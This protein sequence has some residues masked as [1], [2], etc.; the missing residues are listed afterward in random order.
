M[1]FVDEVS[2]TVSSGKGGPGK[3]SF[4]R[5]QM[6]VTVGVAVTLFSE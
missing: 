3:V 6:V 4:L 5:A 1:K 2:I